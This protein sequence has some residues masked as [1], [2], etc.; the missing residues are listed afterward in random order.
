MHSL[1]QLCLKLE[2][3]VSSNCVPCP[4]L[5]AEK[6]QHLMGTCPSPQHWGPI[7]IFSAGY[8]GPTS[9]WATSSQND[10]KNK[11][12]ARWIIMQL[13]S[14]C[15]QYTR[16]LCRWDACCLVVFFRDQLVWTF[17][18][19]D[20]T[21]AWICGECAY[22]LSLIKVSTDPP[23]YFTRLKHLQ[24]QPTWHLKKKIKLKKN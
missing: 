7:L 11:T 15:S 10:W 17:L 1:S 12:T 23:H 13:C 22:A 4:G 21:P 8:Y 3:G 6:I 20:Y 2:F 9:G 18:F 14:S 5:E 16:N 24:S 19:P